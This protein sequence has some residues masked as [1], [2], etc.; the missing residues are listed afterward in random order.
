MAPVSAV[1]LNA[2]EAVAVDAAVRAAGAVVFT[3]PDFIL[4]K[5]NKAPLNSFAVFRP[6]LQEC[7]H[8]GDFDRIKVDT[9][10]LFHR[11]LF[12][13]LRYGF[14]KKDDAFRGPVTGELY[15]DPGGTAN[16]C[17][18]TF[19]RDI[20]EISAGIFGRFP[21]WKRGISAGEKGFLTVI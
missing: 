8:R 16:V 21:P 12:S 9:D 20:Q 1:D 2:N 18:K 13:V 6:A 3:A 17:G 14:A 10:L 5:I 19:H 15:S 11:H 7:I 4:H